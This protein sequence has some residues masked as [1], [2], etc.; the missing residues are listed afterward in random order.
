MATAF[1]Q[2]NGDERGLKPMQS[3]QLSPIRYRRL[4]HYI[5]HLSGLVAYYPL[6]EVSGNALNRAP[7][8]LGSLNGANTD[9]T[10][11]QPGKAGRA[12]SFNGSSSKVTITHNSAFDLLNI[13]FI[14][15]INTTDANNRDILV[16]TAGSKW[17]MLRHMA[18]ATG[19]YLQIYDGANQ[20][21]CYGGK[22]VRDGNWH[23]VAA[24]KDTTKT[25]IYIDG[26]EYNAFEIVGAAVDGSN[27]GNLV[28]GQGV[29]SGGFINGTLQH[30]AVFNRALSAT[31]VLKLTRIAGLA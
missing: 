5:K 17:I 3:D 23:L 15:L 11:A 29:L 7:G 9:I 10:A 22:S 26:T 14:Y 25:K 6:D 18:D 2:L 27:A 16:K 24:V 8:T 28:I 30:I 31:E 12:Y 13:S 4:S 19:A 20:A 21:R 1:R